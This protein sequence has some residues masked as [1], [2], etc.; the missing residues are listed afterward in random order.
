MLRQSPPAFSIF[1]LYIRSLQSSLKKISH[2]Y[3]LPLQQRPLF[4]ILYT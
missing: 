2:L 3:L 4:L 1:I